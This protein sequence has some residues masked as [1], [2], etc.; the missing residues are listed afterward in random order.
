VH[1]DAIW[2]GKVN[3]DCAGECS[4]TPLSTITDA[5]GNIISDNRCDG[6]GINLFTYALR[7]VVSGNVITNDTSNAINI[8]DGDENVITANIV[9]S[10]TYYG[11]DA[12]SGAYRNLI[13]GNLFRLTT[14]HGVRFENCSDNLIFGNII[15][16]SGGAENYSGISLEQSSDN[17]LISSNRISDSAPTSST[18]TNYGIDISSSSCDNNYLSGNLIDGA[19]YIGAGFDRRVRDLGT[20]T[21]YTDKIKMTLERRQ[22]DIGGA[23]TLN[24]SSSPCTYAYIMPTSNVTLALENGK[25]AGDLLIIEN[26]HAT[27]TITINDTSSDNLNLSGAD[28]SPKYTLGQ[29]DTLKLIWNGTRWLE[30]DHSDN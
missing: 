5:T 3:I 2:I 29:Y 11:L 21:K 14:R 7:N 22:F 8:I 24:I 27:R 20:G 30:I 26:G 16:D 13:S 10:P 1:Y 15:E 18:N 4:G 12:W 28:A 23:A 17:N 25:S 9:I 6:G 19:G